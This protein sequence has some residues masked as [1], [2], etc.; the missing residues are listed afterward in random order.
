M[1]FRLQAGQTK[2]EPLPETRV[3]AGVILQEPGF[4]IRAQQLDHHHTPVLAYAFEPAMTISIRKDDLQAHQLAPGPW[5]TELKK[6]LLAGHTTAIITLPNGRQGQVSELAAELALV[7]RGKK[8]VYATDLADTPTNRQRLQEL[9]QYAHTFFCEAC[10]IE[11]DREQA[12]RTGHLTTRA[13]AEIAMAA[14]VARLIPFH[15]S[16]RYIND[17]QQIYDEVQAIYPRVALPP[18]EI[19]SRSTS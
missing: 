8:L 11:A 18:A 12:A 10:F 4:C 1:R 16:Q 9:A 14:E 5:L 15:F 3:E 2:C 7:K 17:C 6:Q 19:T 13:C